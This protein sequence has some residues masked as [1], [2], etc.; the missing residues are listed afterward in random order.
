MLEN[1]STDSRTGR[2]AF[3]V[4]E[5]AA[6]LGCSRSFVRLELAR[7][8]LNG[9]KRGRRVFVLAVELTRYLGADRP[10]GALA[11]AAPR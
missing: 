11:G 4:A 2:L 1:V 5:I 8:R 6:L 10:S 7:G 3:S 9:V